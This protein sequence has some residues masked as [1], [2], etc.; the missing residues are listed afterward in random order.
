MRCGE[1][2]GAGHRCP[3]NV[4]LHVLE[5]LLEVLQLEDV[6]KDN[7]DGDSKSSEEE[8]LMSI[9]HWAAMR[10]QGERTIKLQGYVGNQEV[11]VLI[12]SGSSGNFISETLVQ[13]LQYPTQ[14]ADR[15]HVALADGGRLCS[16]QQIQGLTWWTQG[17]TFVTDVR[18]LKLGCYDMILG[19]EWLEEQVPM[20]IHWV[21]KQLRFAHNGMRITHHGVQDTT[22]AC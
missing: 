18:L 10:L 7:G 3:K 14:M 20:W 8:V 2:W 21:R 13:R 22:I 16:D 5:E 6:N 1:K 15:V 4:P 19:M 12:D 17:Y 9:S 11:L